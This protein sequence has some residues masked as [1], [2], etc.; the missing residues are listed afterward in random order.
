M[1]V[2]DVSKWIAVNAWSPTGSRD[3]VWLAD[4]DITGFFLF[5]ESKLRYPWE[6]WT[7]IIAYE[8]G[9][10]LNVEV[11]R[12]R[13]ALRG[14]VY[15]ALI[16]YIPKM[17]IK[18]AK[19]GVT[20]RQLEV[21]FE[22]GEWILE[23]DPTFDRK[24]GEKHNIWHVEKLLNKDEFREFVRFL[25]FDAIIGNTDRHQDNWALVC[26]AA[27]GRK[28]LP[29]HRLAPAYDNAAGL[30]NNLLEANLPK[31]IQDENALEKFIGK[32]EQH[33]R[34]SEDGKTLVRLNHFDFLR[35]LN[36]KHSFVKGEI[37][38][39]SNFKLE[40]FRR[41]LTDIG[42]ASLLHPQFELTPTRREFMLKYVA[43]RRQILR[44]TFELKPYGE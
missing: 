10:I 36:A 27:T 33:L 24:K 7:E 41:I 39:M 29:I 34:W 4:R 6:F 40:E 9:K 35:N 37:D 38:K 20:I 26:P 28:K 23:V 17:E 32:G 2:I 44:S 42:S 1:N 25:I 13:A 16:D 3:K 31:Y 15:G 43:K 22:G 8:F 19:Q 18:K 12:T 5:K 21:M 11:P 14:S 30:A